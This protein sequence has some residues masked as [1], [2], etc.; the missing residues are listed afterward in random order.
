MTRTSIATL[1]TIVALAGLTASVQGAEA[2]HRAR[3]TAARYVGVGQHATVMN[4]IYQAQQRNNAVI[5]QVQ[6]NIR[7]NQQ[8]PY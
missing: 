7:A 4:N 5:N 6:G 8:H 3:V 1:A 2:R